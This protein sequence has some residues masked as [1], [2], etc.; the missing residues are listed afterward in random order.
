MLDL[1]VNLMKTIVLIELNNLFLFDRDPH[2]SWEEKI[3]HE[4]IDVGTK[5]VHVWNI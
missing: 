2:R 5:K 3:S 1:L 4:I